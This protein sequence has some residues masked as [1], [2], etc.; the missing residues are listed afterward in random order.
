MSGFCATFRTEGT[1]HGACCRLGV[2]K[3]CPGWTT[4]HEPEV[5]LAPEDGVEPIGKVSHGM[6]PACFAEFDRDLTEKEEAQCKTT[7]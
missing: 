4:R 3:I 7:I 6:C 2:I 1:W 5:V